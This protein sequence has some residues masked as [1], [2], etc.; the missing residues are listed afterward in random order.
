MNLLS[1]LVLGLPILTGTL[2]IHLVWIG[3]NQPIDLILKISLGTGIG[4]GISSLLYFVCL[5]FFDG[6]AY[7]VPW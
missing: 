4:L 1:L 7:L 2:L 6:G 3:K 5:I